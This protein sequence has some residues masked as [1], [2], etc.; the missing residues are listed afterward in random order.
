MFAFLLD[1]GHRH[2]DPKYFECTESHICLHPNLVCD[3]NHDCNSDT[4][5][6]DGC[7]ELKT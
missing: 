3:G 7:G 6:E 5:D 1:T 2:C 4:S